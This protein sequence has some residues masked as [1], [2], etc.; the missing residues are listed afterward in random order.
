MG[1]FFWPTVYSVTMN[2]NLSDMIWSDNGAAE[3]D[4]A[5]NQLLQTKPSLFICFISP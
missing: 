5:N 4:V 2:I 1:M 3:L